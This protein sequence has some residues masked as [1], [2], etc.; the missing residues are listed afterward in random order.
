VEA[1]VA[2]ARVRI[3]RFDLDGAEADATRALELGGGPASLEVAGWAAY[4]KRDY[5]LGLRRAE[6][7][8]ERTEDPAVR[9]SCRTLSGRILHASG[10][11]SEADRR[12]SDAVAGAP[13]DVRGV[14]QVFLGGLRI[15]QGRVER[16]CELVDRA[17]LDPSRL[18][19]PFALHHGYLLRA[20]GLGMQGRPVDALVAVEAGR[21]LAIQAGEPGIRFV[22][23][24]DNLRSWVLRNLGLLDQ[25]DEWTQRAL[26]LAGGQRSLMSEM[27]FAG[28]L[29]LIEGLLLAGDAGAAGTAIEGTADLMQWDGSMAW[30]HRQRFLTLSARHALAA[31]DPDRAISLASRVVADCDDRGTSRYSLLARVTLA[32][33][34]LVA[35]HA[36]DHDELDG[37]LGELG[38]SAGLEAW[39]VTAE[40]AAVAGVDRWWRDAE[41]RAGALVARTGE[42]HETMHRYV[43]ETFASLGR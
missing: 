35:G 5:D 7:A 36:I 19:H 22:A 33:A 13:S 28:R 20:L 41:R 21:A 25:A 14:A 23:V 4:Y 32:R 6:E 30:H 31:E 15:H 40:L 38:R 18:G 3:A 24:Q 8:V 1:R 11:L 12:L 42:H 27:Y 17:L 34:R 26:A 2:R 10:H 39:R 37:V 43:A 9:A 16:G 29:D